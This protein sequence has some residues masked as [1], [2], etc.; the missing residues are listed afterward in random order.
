V[1]VERR[2]PVDE[3]GTRLP[4]LVAHPAAIPDGRVAPAAVSASTRSW[5]L[6]V[7]VFCPSIIRVGVPVTPA[8][9][10]ASVLA[11]IQLA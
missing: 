10:A 8:A 11:V 3:H 6:T 4:L 2:R 7:V 5:P 9:A 1:G